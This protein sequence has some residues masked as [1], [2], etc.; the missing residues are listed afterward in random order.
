MGTKREGY[1]ILAREVEVHDTSLV[2][3]KGR[4]IRYETTIE[5][6]ADPERPDQPRSWRVWGRQMRD[7]QQH[8]RACA[9]VH[10]FSVQA[11]RTMARTMFYKHLRRAERTLA[12]T[13]LKAAAAAEESLLGAEGTR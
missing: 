12:A 1:S 8:G 5:A 6:I 9:P 4:A 11:A 10:V 13:H 2:D 3:T 7:T